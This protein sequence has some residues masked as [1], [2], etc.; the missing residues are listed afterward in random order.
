MLHYETFN[1]S[2]PTVSIQGQT[3]YIKLLLPIVVTVTKYGIAFVQW[4]VQGDE[5]GGGRPPTRSPY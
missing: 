1:Q 5:W 3:S 4:Q 2:L